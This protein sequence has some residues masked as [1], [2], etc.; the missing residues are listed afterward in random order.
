MLLETVPKILANKQLNKKRKVSQAL[1]YYVCCE[2]FSA[3][4]NITQFLPNG[5]TM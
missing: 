5:T 2:L 1:I 4:K 3:K